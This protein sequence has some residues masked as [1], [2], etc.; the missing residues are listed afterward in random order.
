MLSL[1][2]QPLPRL[3]IGLRAA[4]YI[5]GRDLIAVDSS[6][7]Q[8]G[9]TG[10]TQVAH[11]DWL[12]STRSQ[13]RRALHPPVIT[14]CLPAS[15]LQVGKQPEQWPLRTPTRGPARADGKPRCGIRVRRMPSC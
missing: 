2:A 1:L 15:L 7:P 5:S 9:H 11:T 4:E 8:E 3:L 12:F 6:K 13:V 10:G 14:R